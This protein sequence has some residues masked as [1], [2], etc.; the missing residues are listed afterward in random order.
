[1]ESM[2]EIYQIGTRFGAANAFLIVEEHLTL[3]D[4]GMRGSHR[5]IEKVV[6]QAGRS[7]NELTQIILTHCHLDHAGSV[8]TLKELTGASVAVH[9]A[10]ANYVSKLMSYPRPKSKPIAK[11]YSGIML[12]LFNTSALTPDVLLKDG[13]M[14]DC[15]GGLKVIHTP[16]HTPGNIC[17]YSSDKRVLFAGDAVRNVGDKLCLPYK[18]F[19]DDWDQAK[20]SV[21]KIAGLEV[22]TIYVGHGN[23]ITRDAVSK[24]N[25]V[26]D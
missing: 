11:L 4:T 19:T 6:K 13:D 21:S 15:L 14:I 2:S 25:S 22:D 23:P 3:I 7:L 12:P 18:M 8:A 5:K 10:D 17:L 16:G 9:E 20:S 1:M 24:L 26:A